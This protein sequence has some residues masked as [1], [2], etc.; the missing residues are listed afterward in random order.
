MNN[1]AIAL[2]TTE[3]IYIKYYKFYTIKEFVE[4]F[5][6]DFCSNKN[7]EYC[8]VVKI[9]AKTVKSNSILKNVRKITA[10]KSYK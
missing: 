5:E 8:T 10:T 3:N 4:E 6:T 7:I 2:F 9:N 1:V